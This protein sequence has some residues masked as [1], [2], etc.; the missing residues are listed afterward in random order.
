MFMSLLIENMVKFYLINSVT[1]NFDKV[2]VLC[3]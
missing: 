3:I 1:H 2:D